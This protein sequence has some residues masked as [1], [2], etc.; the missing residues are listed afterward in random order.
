M[1]T[2][3]HEAMLILLRGGVNIASFLANGPL[4]TL[5]TLGRG[6]ADYD[7]SATAID[8]SLIIMLLTNRMLFT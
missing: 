4:L 3:S 8:K 6:A 1:V 5:G 2:S 7:P